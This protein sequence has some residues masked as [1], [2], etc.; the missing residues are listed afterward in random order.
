ML[1]TDKFVFLHQPKTGGTFV[2]DVLLRI[3]GVA[4][5]A[6]RIGNKTN[7]A[8]ETPYGELIARGPKHCGCAD[9]PEGH[10]DKMVLATVRNPFDRYVSLYEFGWWKKE[11]YR[12]SYRA[13]VPDLDQ[14]YPGFPEIGFA[15]YL[16]FANRRE[17]AAGTDIGPQT[18]A[19]VGQYFKDPTR[20]LAEHDEEYFSSGRYRADMFDVHFLQTGRLNHDLHALLLAAGYPAADIAFILELGKV[21]PKAPAEGRSREGRSW[22]SYYSA[23]SLE[24]VRHRERHLLTLFPDF[25]QSAELLPHETRQAAS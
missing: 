6:R 17:I 9:I 3:H 24:F 10:K 12:D 14:R 1:I 21:V 8:Y 23:E 20:V 19:F 2:I 13:I 11:E 5:N 15:D 25:G 16:R 7:R 22:E 18:V 4:W